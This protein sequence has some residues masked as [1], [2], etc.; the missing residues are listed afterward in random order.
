[1]LWKRK[2][3]LAISWEQLHGVTA[4]DWVVFPWEP[5]VSADER[6]I[7]MPESAA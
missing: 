4:D 7:A 1:M 2:T 5:P 3:L 6:A